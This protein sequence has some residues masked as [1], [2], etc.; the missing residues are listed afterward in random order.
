MA[1]VHHFAYGWFNPVMAFSLAFLGSM[2]GLGCAARARA[3]TSRRRRARWLVLAAI[4]IG[5]V[6]I[7]LMHFMAMLG[8]DVPGSLVRYDP[9]LTA[10]SLLI[11]IVTV[12]IGL[13]VIG[14]GRSTLPRVLVG[15]ALTGAGVVAM[16]YT[17]MAA[18][19]LAGRITYETRLQLASI[20]I[21]VV[22]ATLAMW[23]ASWVQRGGHVAV[24]A[25]IMTCAIWGMHYTGM[26]SV[27]VELG[28]SVAD[29]GGV[30]PLLLIIPMTVVTGAAL[31]AASFTALQAM[32]EEELADAPRA[33]LTQRPSG[34]RR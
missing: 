25:V 12:G 3:A 24:A 4:S 21:A 9:G 13:F 6:G 32:T 16:H 10:L 19:Q 14:F 29:V 23:F 34:V 20:G 27:R 17:G 30:S 31:V 1:H 18:L 15:G 33:Q 2:L 22:A 26:A 28:G 7:W 11:A 5:G 8:F